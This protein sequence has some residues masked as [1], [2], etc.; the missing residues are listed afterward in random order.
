MQSWLT[1][2]IVAVLERLFS[3][4]W[5]WWQAQKAQEKKNTEIDAETK[6][7]ADNLKDSVTDE[8]DEKA[9]QDILK[10]NR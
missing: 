7:Q 8:E 9:A 1:G 3:R 6:E 2:L 5:A 4:A 10:R